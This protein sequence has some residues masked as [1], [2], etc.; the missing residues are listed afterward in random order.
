MIESNN[1]F[2]Q[3][4]YTAALFER[5][6]DLALFTNAEPDD[7]GQITLN[8]IILDKSIVLPQMITPMFLSPGPELKNVK[9]A[10]ESG[11]T[12]VGLIS[13]SQGGYLSIALELAAGKLIKLPDGN[14]STLVQGR[15]RI[16]VSQVKETDTQMIVKG[17][18]ISDTPKKSNNKLKALSKTARTLFEQVI[19]L[20]RTIPDEA[21]LYALNVSDPGELADMIATAIS[22]EVEKRI[23]I[24]ELVDPEERMIFVNQLLAEEIDILTLEE[25]IQSKVQREM[26]RGQR[27]AYLREQVRAIQSELGEGDVWD[28]EID[29]YRTRLDNLNPPEYVKDA[30]QIEIRRLSVNPAFAPETGIIRNYIEWLLDLPWKEPVDKEISIPLAQKTLEKNHF[31]LKKAKERILEYLAVRKLNPRT[32]QPI[33]CFI[34]PPGTGKTSLGKSIAESLG[35]KFVRV[36]LGG[37]K[38][39]AEIRGHRRTYIGAMPGRVI[40]SIKQAG[41]SNPVFMLDEIDKLGND[42][43]GDPT[44]AL[45]EVLDPEQNHAYSDHYIELPFDLSRVFF[46]TSANN[47]ENIPSALLDRMEVI[48]F[49][50]YIDEEKTEIARKF[51]I[52]KQVSLNGLTSNELNVPNE[53]VRK[54]IREYT[55]EA[56]VRNLEREIAKICRKIAKLKSLNKEIPGLITEK[57]LRKFLGPPSY[58]TFILERTEGIGVSTAVAWTENGG[59]IMP[60]EVVVVEGKGNL[61]ITG[62]IGEIMQE[63]AQAAFSYIKSRADDFEIEE[64]FF[65]KVDVHLHIPEGAVEK[66]GPSAGITICIAI[67]SAIL[68]RKVHLDIG[69]TGE[70]TLGGKL[71]PVGGLREKIYAAHRGG[72]KQVIIPKKNKN[73]LTELPASLK[74][75]IKITMA[76]N[77]DQV[78][79]I[80]LFPG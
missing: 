67:L 14:Y 73:D 79:R 37:V 17:V 52:P 69:I 72:L 28:Q 36:S 11:K 18:P 24:I 1:Q 21:H 68:N 32:N 51:L 33:L 75:E 6:E 59:E 43:R 44:S 46:I 31:G 16:R 8:A 27:E 30:V 77:I 58:S 12:L 38:D 4:E 56:G 76:E 49:P 70:I 25:E 39:E 13:N 45:M 20:D 7:H 9:L 61:Q 74:R 3:D 34:G 53:T 47:I 5:A 71:L 78:I 42:F 29:E 54:I 66:D 48:E 41:E 23:H 22:P 63:S 64:E 19:Q 62:K 55:Y 57:E 40:Q 50:G 10:Q 60:V 80:V 2:D 35:R 15:R 65:E 26:D